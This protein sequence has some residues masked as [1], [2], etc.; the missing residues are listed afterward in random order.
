MRGGRERACARPSM[1][2]APGTPVER[3]L[4]TAS[5]Y[6]S[7]APLSSRNM[8]GVAPAGAVSRPS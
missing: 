7:G 2:T 1:A 3:P 8:P 4:V 5:G 6:D